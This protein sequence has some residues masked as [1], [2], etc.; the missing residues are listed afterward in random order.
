MESKKRYKIV[1][2]V[3]EEYGDKLREAIGNAGAGKIGNYSHC[4]FTTKGCS[5]FKPL[6]GANPFIGNVGKTE[7]VKE[8]RIETLCKPEKLNDVIKAIKEVH[9]Y[10]EPA[11]DIYSIEVFE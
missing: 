5:S 10:E 9:P 1:V 2:F 11:I 6:P 4:L 7:E 3:P 8:D